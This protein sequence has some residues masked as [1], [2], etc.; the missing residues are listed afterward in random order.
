VGIGF[1]GFST[2]KAQRLLAVTGFWVIKGLTRSKRN[3]VLLASVSSKIVR[4][5]LQ[6]MHIV[7]KTE[8]P[9]AVVML[10]MKNSI[11]DRRGLVGLARFLF[12]LASARVIILDDYLP[13]LNWLK[14]RR[15][16]TV[17]QLWHAA[18]AFKRVGYSRRGMPGGPGLNSNLHRGY[19]HVVCSSKELVEQYAEAFNISSGRVH[20]LGVPRFARY[21]S[22]GFQEESKRELQ[23]KFGIQSGK[24]TVLVAPTFR[25]N[26]QKSARS[27]MLLDVV[28]QAATE[29]K[30]SHVFLIRDHPFAVN[31]SRKFSSKAPNVHDVS[32][33]ANEIEKLVAGT[34]LLV[35]DY[36]S[37]IFEFALLNK[38]TILF[39]PDLIEYQST[40]GLYFPLDEYAY[41]NMATTDK[42]LVKA[43][44]KPNINEQR[45]QSLKRK[46]LSSCQ[47]SSAKAIFEKLIAP[48]L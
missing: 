30:E 40:R 39:V 37:I 29:L 33:T 20:A 31:R 4:G 42:Q 25:G 11:S 26:G 5:N 35:T 3:T 15:S 14:L 28:N 12:R 21:F 38:P 7:I 19:S 34:D 32:E 23:K 24:K 44:D 9:D 22:P 2:K 36:S 18:G 46:H 43:I 41:A 45:L 10:E 16:Q 47:P 1:R 13:E 8:A 17:V 6:E 48:A 27:S